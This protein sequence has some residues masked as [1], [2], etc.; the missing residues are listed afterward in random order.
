MTK[1]KKNWNET[2]TQDAWAV[3]KYLSEMVE[4][5]ETLGEIGPCVSFFGSARTAVN[6]ET[7]QLT[8]E[9]AYLLACQG[10]GI[11]TGGGPGIME[12]ANKGARR[13]QGKSVGLCIRLPQEQETNPYVDRDKQ[14]M[15][16][17]FFI[18]KLMFVKYAQGFVVM[19]GGFGTMDELFEAL[20]LMQVEKT[21]K[22]PLVLF[23][24]DYWAPVL[25]FMRNVLVKR[26]FIDADD[27]EILFVVNT[28]QE[29]VAAIEQFYTQKK[30]LPN[31]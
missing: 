23:G 18:R 19:P 17:Y 2:K 30:H 1:R 29:A 10:Y 7:Y 25:S 4:G 8:E 28:P 13:A 14:L 31:F 26:G 9:T 24:E 20:T 21:A 15:F 5:F 22:F 11:I 27:L 6:D 3:F 16:R 12:A